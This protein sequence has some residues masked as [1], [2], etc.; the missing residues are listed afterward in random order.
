MP[1][2]NHFMVRIET[3]PEGLSADPKVNFNGHTLPLTKVDGGTGPGETYE[4]GLAPMSFVHRMSLIGPDAGRWTIGKM[5]VTYDCAGEPPY[6]VNFGAVTL[7]ESNEANVWKE[8][9][10]V[11][12][13]V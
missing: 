8:K 7:D 6:T 2:L 11:V 12:W 4:G 5:S 3:G 9:P 1:R 13:D 10:P